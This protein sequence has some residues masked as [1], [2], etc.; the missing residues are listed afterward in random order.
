MHFG[1][2]TGAGSDA[3]IQTCAVRTATAAA[4]PQPRREKIQPSPTRTGCAGHSA[5][6]MIEGF[7]KHYRI[8]RETSRAKEELRGRRLARPTAVRD[9]VQFYDDRR[10]KPCSACTRNS[11]R[12]SIDDAT[13]QTAKLQ[14]IGLLIKLQTTG[15]GETFFTSVTTKILHRDSTTPHLYPAGDFHRL[16]RILPTHLF[17]TTRGIEGSAPIIPDHRGFRLATSFRRPRPDELRD[18]H[19]RETSR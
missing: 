15:A 2:D 17:A 10:T 3:S 12:E 4:N 9:R 6:A 5:Q 8:F 18:A 7:N 16:H 11:T 1:S 13:R 14:Y 19:R